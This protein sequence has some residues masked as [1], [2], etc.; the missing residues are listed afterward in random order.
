MNIIELKS[1]SKI[2]LDW[3]EVNR[4]AF[5]SSRVSFH[6]TESNSDLATGTILLYL[7]TSTD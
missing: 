6:V 4:N 3:L 5:K 2:N 1:Q 7:K